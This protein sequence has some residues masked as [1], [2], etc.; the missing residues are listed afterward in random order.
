MMMMARGL[1]PPALQLAACDGVVCT[2][3]SSDKGIKEAAQLVQKRKGIAVAIGRGWRGLI[4]GVWRVFTCCA[5]CGCAGDGGEEGEAANSGR[6]RTCATEFEDKGRKSGG[7][8]G[9]VYGVDGGGEGVQDDEEVGSCLV[10]VF[11]E[12][13]GVVGGQDVGA[14]SSQRRKSFR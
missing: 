13:Q 14:Q 4:V 10:R 1:P 6:R 7:R 9:G 2:A 5:G 8:R 11:G 12:G 3:N